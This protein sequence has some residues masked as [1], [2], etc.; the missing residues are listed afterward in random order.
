MAVVIATPIASWS[1]P[2]GHVTHGCRDR[3]GRRAAPSGGSA[4]ACRE[5]C[6]AAI[7]VESLPSRLTRPLPARGRRAVWTPYFF[8]G[9]AGDARRRSA[10]DLPPLEARSDAVPR[11]GASRVRM[12]RTTLPIV[13]GTRSDGRMQHSSRDFAL[14]LV[15]RARHKLSSL[16]LVCCTPV[17]AP[18]SRCGSLRCLLT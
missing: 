17:A 11:R 2:L 4:P 6:W 16:R 5:R 1:V 7:A 8:F 12:H 18:A 13:V 14:R 10:F 15:C 3:Q 9:V